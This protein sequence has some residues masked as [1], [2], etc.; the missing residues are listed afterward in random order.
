MAPPGGLSKSDY[1]TR[2]TERKFHRQ[3]PQRKPDP[4][5]DLSRVVEVTVLPAALPLFPSV[6]SLRYFPPLSSTGPE[7]ELSDGY[8]EMRKST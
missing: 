3:P 7:T 8:G 1:P 5:P 4:Y 6:L 2:I